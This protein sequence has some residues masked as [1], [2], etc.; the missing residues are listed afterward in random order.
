MSN[1][2]FSSKDRPVHMGPYPTELLARIEQFPELSNIPSAPQ[3]I[4]SNKTH[5]ASIIN[6]MREHQA[7]M[8]AIRDG[9]INKAIADAPTNLVERTN[10]LKSFGYFSDAAVVGTCLLPQEAL[11]DTPYSNPDIDR[12]AN[13]L[14]T[15]QTKSLAAGIDTIM[16]SLKEAIEAPSTNID[17]HTHCLVF[18]Y[19]NPRTPEVDEDGTA[20]IQDAN[21][22]RAGLLAAE[23]AVVLSNYLR[24]LGYDSR[25]HTVSSSDVD[26]NKLAVTAGLL[27]LEHGELKHPYIGSRFGLAAVTTNFAIEPDKPLASM[28]EQPKSAFGAVWKYGTSSIKNAT[29][30]VPYSNRRFVDGAHPFEKLKRVDIPTTYIDE[31]NIPRVPKRTDL[32][33]RA[34]FGDLGKKVQDA[35]KN[36]HYVIKSAPSMAQRKPLGAFVLLQD[37][38]VAK[39]REP[40]KPDEASRLIKATCYWLGIDAVGISRCPTWAWYSHD[41]RGDVIDPPHDQSINMVVDQGYE[42]MEGSSGDDWIAVA[43]SMRAYLRFSL[44]GGVIARQIRNMGYSAKAHTVMDGDVLQPP[45]LLL[46]GL[47]EVSRIGEVILNPFLGPRLK[48]GTVTTDLPL[49]H[50]KPINFGLQEFCNSCNKCAR[51]CPAGA[52][53]AGPKTMFNGYEIWKSDSQKCTSYRLTNLGGAMCGRCMKTCP[54]NLEGIFKEKPFRWAAMNIPKLAPALAKLDDIVDNGTLNPVK[55]WWWDLEIEEDG[56]YRPTKNKVNMRSLSKDLELKFKDQTMAVYPATLAPPP[57]LYPYTMDREKGIK[58]YQEMVSAEEHK[59]RVAAG[60]KSILHRYDND[61]QSPVIPAIVTVAE[62]TAKGIMK[63]EFQTISGDP[64]PKWQAG[65]HLDIVVAPEFLRQYS[66]SGDPADR[67][68]YQIVVLREDDG[69]GGSKLMHRVF[70]KGRHVFF[71]QPINHFA[72]NHNA[73]KTLLMGGGIGITPLIAMAHE[74]YARKAAF[75]LHYSGRKRETMGLLEDISSFPWSDHVTLHVS[76]EGTRADFHSIMS[77]YQSGWNVYACGAEAYMSAVMD[78]AQ[79]AGF[80]ED[81]RHLEYFS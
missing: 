29:N 46:S 48:S 70:T 54:W 57:Y 15:K 68:K 10:H 1:R 40:L 24:V 53:T 44:L 50:D 8:D 63:Y 19:E 80:P 42:T 71:S 28:S 74:L 7:M 47:G 60:D 52:I 64:L 78:A 14:K 41:A 77:G 45:L 16:A 5:K 32:F 3:L 35:S 75:E 12:L 56:G 34:K 38:K 39:K 31:P 27:T 79:R 76:N 18:L 30:S 73:T 33:T 9:L 72:L 23:T 6:A 13:D 49:A 51:E 69:R 22:H 25:G 26:L 17:G 81:A 20:W 4:F 58:A 43:Q 67:S 37:G 65:A 59:K 21:A 62:E 2:F 61:E 36:G 66:M 11:L 55:K